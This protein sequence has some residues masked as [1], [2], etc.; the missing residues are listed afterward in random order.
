M[1]YKV[2]DKVKVREDLVVDKEYGSDVFIE[3]MEQ[4]KGK[5]ATITLVCHDKY[6]IDLDEGEWYWTDEMFE[7]EFIDWDKKLLDIDDVDSKAFETEYKCIWESNE[8]TPLTVEAL[9]RKTDLET[10][11]LVISISYPTCRAEANIGFN[12]ID[13]NSD[14]YKRF[15]AAYG[16]FIV[17]EITIAYKDNHPILMISVDYADED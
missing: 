17:D 16:D 6:C 5:T 10:L 14:L 2:G 12:R 7:D 3:E 13:R 4:H 11:G 8:P 9:L 1:K 15:V